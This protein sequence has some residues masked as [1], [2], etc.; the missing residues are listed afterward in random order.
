MLPI[1]KE[2][3]VRKLTSRKFWVAV[4]SFV[5]NI[6]IFLGSTSDTV[7]R[8]GALIMAG[9]SV[10]AYI[11]GEGLADSSDSY[12]VTAGENFVSKEMIE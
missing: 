1:T 6:M 3:I 12:Y 8:V 7:V 9:A 10:I 11:I 2:D 5:T 4:V